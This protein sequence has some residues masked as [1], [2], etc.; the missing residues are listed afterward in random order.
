[1]RLLNDSEK[2][3]QKDIKEM[4]DKRGIQNENVK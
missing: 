4:K 3:C 2:T 1:M